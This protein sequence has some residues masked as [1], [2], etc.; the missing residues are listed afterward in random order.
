MKLL[1][2]NHIIT[3][4]PSFTELNDLGEGSDP[5]LNHFVLQKD[6]HTPFITVFLAEIE[7][8]TYPNPSGIHYQLGTIDENGTFKKDPS[9][10]KIYPQIIE[11]EKTPS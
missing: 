6:I 9:R 3:S 8:L 7:R 2:K 10:E 1:Q 11:K 5:K 4:F